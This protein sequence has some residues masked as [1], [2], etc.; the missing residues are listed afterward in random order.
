MYLGCFISLLSSCATSYNPN[1]TVTYTS[2]RPVHIKDMPIPETA[3]IAVY[4]SIDADYNINV[5]VENL[6]DDILNIDQTKSF[7]ISPKNISKSYFDPTV[8]TTTNS[9][10]YSTASGSSFNLG[11]IANGF[12]IG[13]AAGS[14][15][16]ATTVGKS[17]AQ[18][19]TSIYTEVMADM[20]VVSIGPRGKMA[21]SKTFKVYPELSPFLSATPDTSPVK[22]SIVICY[23]FND[24]EH[25]EI[26]TNEFYINSHII[27]S[28]SNGQ[29]N[30]AIRSLLAKKPNATLE[31]WYKVSSSRGD[32][33]KNQTILLNYQ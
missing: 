3:D 20:P 32:Q 6:T 4:Y 15:M 25:S 28:V 14:L 12:G 16:R 26:I 33:F 23:S 11:G 30:D 13:G 7:Y 8:R 17:D 27:E 10:S 22:F 5:L 21:M 29:T 31:P 9:T 2:I 24:G 18:T 1:K 19:S